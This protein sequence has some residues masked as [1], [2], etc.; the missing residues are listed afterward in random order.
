MRSLTLLLT[1]TSTS[2]AL[3]HEGHGAPPGHLDGFV[4]LGAALVAAAV[5]FAARAFGKRR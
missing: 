2:T 4:L 1:L 5:F 3:A